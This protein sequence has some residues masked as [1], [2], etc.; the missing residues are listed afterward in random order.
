MARKD[1]LEQAI[2]ESYKIIRE[3]ENIIRTSERPEEKARARRVI[4][5]GTYT[6]I[7][8]PGGRSSSYAAVPSSA[9]DRP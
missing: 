8:E 2:R 9:A 6:L 4:D 5:Q 7:R 1:D 3:Y